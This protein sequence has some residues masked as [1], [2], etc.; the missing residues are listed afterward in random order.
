MGNN[1]KLQFAVRA[2]IAMAGATAAAPS[3]FSQTAAASTEPAELQEVVVTGSRIQQNPNDV[4]ISPIIS[5]TALEIAQTGLVRTE[6]LL[7]NLPQVVAENSSGQS[8]SSNGTATVSLR[9]LGSQRTL[10]LIDGKR[11]APGGGLGLVASPDINQI[12]AAMIQ[13]VDVLTGG[14]SAV[15]GADAV[16]G[17]VN[18][19][20]DTHFQGVRLDADYG[21]GSFHNDNNQ[22]LGLLGAAHDFIPPSTTNAGYN[23]SAS[24]LAGSNFADG[25]GNA[26]VYF[27]YLNT[28]PAQGSQYDFA[29]CSLNTPSTL[30]GPGGLSCGG[31]G[32]P[33]T[34]RFTEYGTVA[35]K[36]FV[37]LAPT[38]AVAGPGGWNPYTSADSYNYGALSY[39]QRQAQRYTAGAFLNYD[40]SDYA[41]VYSQFMFARNSSQAAYGPSGAFAFLTPVINCATNPLLTAGELASLCNA[42]AIAANQ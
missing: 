10:V 21:Y 31:S 22:Y 16:A 11:M 6:D 37:A 40:V 32:T 36:T 12:P 30:P 7:N 20:M 2:A 38:Y 42:G 39:L 25:K 3:A 5:V 41:N 15:Y 19:V 24:F 14:A 17:V 23:R 27:T 8:I 13:R 33:A 34:G 29:G 26:T 1:R 9:G 35:G 4:S 28:A 18:F